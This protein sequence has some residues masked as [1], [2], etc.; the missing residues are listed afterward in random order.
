VSASVRWEGLDELRAALRNLPAELTAEASQIIDTTADTAMSAMLAEYP[1]GQLRDRL[2][3]K[4][5]TMGTFGTGVQ[6]KN[7]SGWAWAWEH[8]TKLRHRIKSG[9]STGAEWGGSTP[10]HTFVRNM[11]QPRR[12]MFDQFKALLERAGLRVSGEA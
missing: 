8:G 5:L 2:T 12:A 9:G 3:R 7:A 10:P 6:I 1:A 4:T 11:T